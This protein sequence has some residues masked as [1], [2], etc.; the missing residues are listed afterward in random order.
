MSIA[1]A[2]R[3]LLV[4]NGDVR[5]Y[6][7]HRIFHHAADQNVRLPHL[8]IQQVSAERPRTMEGDSHYIRG[9]VAVEI[10]ANDVPTL[11]ELTR[12]IVGVL[13]NFRG[14]ESW[15]GLTVGYLELDSERDLKTDP[16]DGQ[17]LPL[18][19]CELEFRYLHENPPSGGA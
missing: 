16:A 17:G 13:D 7:E 1:P 6:T 18:F 4:L 19:G 9:T 8:V 12:Q 14:L 3:S 5:L 11:K 2:I 10:Y 15:T